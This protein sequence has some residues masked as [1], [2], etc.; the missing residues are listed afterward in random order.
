[1]STPVHVIIPALDEEDA[2]P[3]LLEKLRKIGPLNVVVVDNGSRDRTAAVA[4]AHGATVVTEPLRGYGAACLAG[5]AALFNRPS[6]EIVVFLDAD[7][8]DDPA[9]LPALTAAIQRGEAD[10]V[11][12]SRNLVPGERGALTVP[13]RF[14]NWL[15][16]RLIR[17]LWNT[18]ASDLAPCRAVRLGVLRALGMNDTGFG[19]TVQM[20][21]R[22]ARSGYRVSEIPSRYRRR[23]AGRSKI[24]G[25]VAGSLRAGCTILTVIAR[26]FFAGR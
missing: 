19:W 26:E 17:M 1:M 25:T 12:A 18:P 23:R 22:A 2:L 13:Q 20:Q 7:G 21:I 15:A 24:S 9:I 5:I 16:C 10:I 6:T 8:S 14:G 3:S 4:R 11:L